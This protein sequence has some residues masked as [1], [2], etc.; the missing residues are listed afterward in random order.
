MPVDGQPIE[1]RVRVHGLDQAP[2]SAIAPIPDHKAE[3]QR[4]RAARRADRNGHKLG[5]QTTLAAGYMMLVATLADS[6]CATELL[7]FY[8]HRRQVAFGFKRLTSL[9]HNQRPASPWRPRQSA[10]RILLGAIPRTQRPR[11]RRD[12]TH[13]RDLL[14][15]GK[16]QR[17]NQ[18][19]SPSAA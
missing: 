13:L 12:L 19:D 14:I 3:K 15:E 6:V 2:R 7:I 9:G 18:A 16:R 8:R 10:R 5:D 17:T 4:Q 11:C 1:H